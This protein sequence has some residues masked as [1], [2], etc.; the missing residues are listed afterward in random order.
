MRTTLD[1]GARLRHS[2]QNLKP[3]RGRLLQFHPLRKRRKAL[4]ALIPTVIPYAGGQVEFA[5]N[6]HADPPTYSPLP[7]PLAP[8]DGLATYLMVV[9]GYLETVAMENQS[10][11]YRWLRL[12][13]NHI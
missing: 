6:M 8:S 4:N 9:R 3:F 13:M 2:T 1:D 5:V 12:H 10:W 7:S 11:T